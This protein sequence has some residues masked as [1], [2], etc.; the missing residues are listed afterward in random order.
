[1]QAEFLIGDIQLLVIQLVPRFQW[2]P[3]GQ[4]EPYEFGLIGVAAEKLYPML[5][6]VNRSSMRERDAS[7]M[8]AVNEVCDTSSWRV[9]MRVSSRW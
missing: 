2:L 7:S 4:Q 5:G 9:A 8:G 1:M 6:P 3:F